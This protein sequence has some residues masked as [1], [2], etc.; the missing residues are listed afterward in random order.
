MLAQ[1]CGG[2]LQLRTC[3]LALLGQ[4]MIPGVEG[5]QRILAQVCVLCVWGGHIGCRHR[6]EWGGEEETLRRLAQCVYVGPR[7]RG[8][9]GL[10][11]GVGGP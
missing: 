5:T 10:G 8:G 2:D 4:M 9:G 11:L 1:V 6:C 3:A 7:Q